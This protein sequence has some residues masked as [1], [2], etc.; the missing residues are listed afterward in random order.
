MLFS[1]VMWSPHAEMP[2]DSNR[3]VPLDQLKPAQ[4]IVLEAIELP[5]PPNVH[6]SAVQPAGFRRVL[7]ET[8]EFVTLLPTRTSALYDGSG[9]FG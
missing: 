6:C 5:E 3:V 7:A 4:S 8:V 1:I 9:N 2:S